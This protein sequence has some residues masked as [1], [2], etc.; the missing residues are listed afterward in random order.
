MWRRLKSTAFLLLFLSSLVPDA[1]AHEKDI[2]DSCGFLDS[3]PYVAV[4]AVAAVYGVPAVLAASG[5]TAAG[6]AGG[7][8]AS[9]MMK[10]SAV[11]NGGG[12][13]AGGVVAFLQSCGATVLSA[14]GLATGGAV[15]GYEFFQNIICNKKAKCEKGKC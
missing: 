11:A 5:F 1:L 6:I 7:T 9:W 13:P 4:G 12:V 15:A 3:I 10:I 2:E 8:V 14:K